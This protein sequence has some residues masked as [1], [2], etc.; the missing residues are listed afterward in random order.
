VHRGGYIFRPGFVTSANPVPLHAS[1]FRSDGGKDVF[2]IRLPPM[3]PALSMPQTLR[4]FAN[5]SIP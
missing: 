3:K 2:L 1:R 4:I 5:W